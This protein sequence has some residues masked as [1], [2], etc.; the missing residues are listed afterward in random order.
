MAFTEGFN[1]YSCD[2]STCTR[3]KY[4]LPGSTAAAEYTERA[5]LD[6]NGQRISAW[7]CKEHAQAFDALVAGHDAD[8]AAF[9]KSGEVE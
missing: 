4:A 7:L 9:M 8:F 2:V 1:R 6:Q 5:Y 3:A